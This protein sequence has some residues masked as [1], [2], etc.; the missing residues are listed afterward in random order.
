M[1]DIDV[2]FPEEKNKVKSSHPHEEAT[3][4]NEE[5]EKPLLGERLP[6]SKQA[7]DEK[8]VYRDN[9]SGCKIFS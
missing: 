8:E 3:I 4:G 9:N 2:D 6:S 5:D 1:K 7:E